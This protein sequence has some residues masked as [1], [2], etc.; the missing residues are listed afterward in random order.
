M[1]KLPPVC[2]ILRRGHGHEFSVQYENID[3]QNH[4][5]S[6]ISH[7]LSYNAN[8]GLTFSRMA[9]RPMCLWIGIQL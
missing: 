8:S 4:N 7:P 2:I 3:D 9:G 1:M 5:T 6:L